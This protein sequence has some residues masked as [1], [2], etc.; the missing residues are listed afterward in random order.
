VIVVIFSVWVPDSFP[1][2]D[3]VKQVLTGNAVTGLIALSL[4]IP[5]CARVFDLSVAY[6]ASLSGVTAAYL[7]A[8]GVGLAGAIAAGIGA[9]VLV[10]IINA[11]VCVVLGV[12]SFIGTLA[13]GSLI[14]A[15]ITLV[16]HDIAINDARLA[17]SFADIGQLEVIGLTLPVFYT[18][19]AAAIIWFLL[20]HTA[21]GRR[22]YATGFNPEAARLAGVQI[23]KLR[24]ISLVI[25]GF[26]AGVAGVVLTSTIGS[27]SP[28]SS[29]PLSCAGGASTPGER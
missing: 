17:G 28:T 18:I 15:F 12:D 2:M 19:G 6:I 27:G 1:T 24:F 13:T 11:F 3:T 9:G 25:S 21:T 20:E 7:L 4:V 22:F 14:Q 16:T 29:A 5:L 10:G 23:N 26:I 8:H